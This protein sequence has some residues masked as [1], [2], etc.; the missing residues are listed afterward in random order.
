MSREFYD[1]IA[2]D[3]WHSAHLPRTRTALQLMA[4][5]SVRDV[6]DVGCG[7]GDAAVEVRKVTNAN[8]RCVDVSAVA[9]ESCRG[10]G[11]DARRVDVNDE[12]LPFD[13][14]MFDL[15]YLAEVIEHLVRPD[16][17]VKEI[18]RVL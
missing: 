17:A 2:A 7:E 16:R 8:V 15:V 6:L 5:L 11:F 1:R 18:R 9:V 10:R 3:G 12:P 13:D 14:E 4:A